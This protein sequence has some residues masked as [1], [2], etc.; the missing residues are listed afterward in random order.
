VGGVADVLGWL[1]TVGTFAAYLLAARGR[2]HPTSLGY[3]AMNTLGGILGGAAS[4]LYGVWPSFA[5]NAVWAAVGAATLVRGLH[6]RRTTLRSR[7]R[8]RAGVTG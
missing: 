8:A 7:L 4:L 3:A 2:L 1:G 6:A 5:S